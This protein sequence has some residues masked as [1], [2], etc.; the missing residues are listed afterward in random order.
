M[1]LIMYFS[2][3]LIWLC[4]FPLIFVS[5]VFYVSFVFY[6]PPSPSSAR[7]PLGN[8]TSQSKA[9]GEF[10][11][12]SVNRQKLIKI[13]VLESQDYQNRVWIDIPQHIHWLISKS[14]GWGVKLR[15]NNGNASSQSKASGEF[16]KKMSLEAWNLCHF[17]WSMTRIR[18]VSR[19]CLY[20]L[21]ASSFEGF[22]WKFVFLSQRRILKRVNYNI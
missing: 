21:W 10:L 11:F 7:A 20:D 12:F 5:L 4:P 2:H 15:T 19:T 14:V 1:F 3:Y 8:V 22:K 6:L 18:M 16:S 9:I 17:S 13:E